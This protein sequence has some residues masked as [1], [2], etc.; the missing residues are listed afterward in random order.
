LK[1]A[2]QWPYFGAADAAN[3]Q[4][5]TATCC[6]AHLQLRFCHVLEGITTIF[7]RHNMAHLGYPSQILNMHI[8]IPGYVNIAPLSF[9]EESSTESTIK[10]NQAH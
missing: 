10:I 1:N 4:V 8:Y 5:F 2:W 6:K 3:G 9:A 7:K